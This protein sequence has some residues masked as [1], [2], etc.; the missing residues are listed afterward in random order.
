MF[1]AVSGRDGFFLKQSLPGLWNSSHLGD[2]KSR[3]VLTTWVWLQWLQHKYG[4][5]RVFSGPRKIGDEY[6][7][8]CLEG[9]RG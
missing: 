3:Q 1:P 7:L 6:T 2:Q 8:T 9:K 5:R 4:E